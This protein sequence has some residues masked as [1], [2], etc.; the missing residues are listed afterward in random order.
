MTVRAECQLPSG[1]PVDAV[2]TGEGSRIADFAT[3]FI[4]AMS[5]RL[6][7]FKR[8]GDLRREVGP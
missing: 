3:D 8:S 6:Q 2:L 1:R 5:V 7:R 4:V